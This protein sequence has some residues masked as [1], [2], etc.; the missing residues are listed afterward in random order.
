MAADR[1]AVAGFWRDAAE[2]PSGHSVGDPY[3]RG[4]LIF[5]GFR[6]WH[7]GA[8]YCYLGENLVGGRDLRWACGG[9]GA[10]RRG[11]RQRILHREEGGK[12]EVNRRERDNLPPRRRGRRENRWIG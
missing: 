4:F 6:L 2:R 10:Q 5:Y 9:G 8:G 7:L 11:R 12:A 3:G 1:R